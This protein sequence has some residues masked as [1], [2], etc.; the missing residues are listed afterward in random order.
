MVSDECHGLE[1]RPQQRQV[2]I[3]GTTILIW[4]VRRII[5]LEFARLNKLTLGFLIGLLIVQ[6]AASYVIYTQ[7]WSHAAT[8]WLQEILIANMVLLA[9]GAFALFILNRTRMYLLREI[10]QTIGSELHE[11]ENG[12]RSGECAARNG[13][14][15]TGQLELRTG[16]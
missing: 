8:E 4:R 1:T 6:V 3:N 9:V 14:D 13:F 12:Q 10:S 5:N 11:L 15:F 16:G 7:V 2:I